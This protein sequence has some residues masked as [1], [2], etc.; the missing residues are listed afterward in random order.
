MRSIFAK[1]ITVHLLSA[2]VVASLLSILMDRE[3]SRRMNGSF[4]THGEVVAEALAKSV[5]PHL[6]RGDLNSV[7]ATIEQVLEI[8]DVAWAYVTAPDGQVVA[9]TFEPTIPAWVA[10]R[11]PGQSRAWSLVTIHGVKEPL[12][13]FDEPVSTGILGAVHVGFERDTLV[14]SIHNTKLV[15]LSSIVVVMLLATFAV[16]YLTSRIIKPMR[17][18][19]AAAM[20]FGKN[21]RFVFREIPVH[22]KDEV[23]VLTR[24]FNHMMG[25]IGDHHRQLEHRVEERT[26]MLERVNR[27]LR[28]LS[29]SNQALV[30]AVGEDELLQSVCRTIVE[31]GEY[32]LAWVGYREDD[33]EKT[34]RPVA[35]AGEAGGY[36]DFVKVTWGLTSRGFGPSGTAVRTGQPCIMN[37]MLSNPAFE[38]WREEAKRRQF[39]SMLAL[40]LVSE[41]H[42]FGVLNIYSELE[43]AF[44]DREVELLTE[45]AGNL[46]YGVIALRTREERRRAEEQLKTAKEAAEAANLAKSS[47]L[48]NMSHEIR[49]P[50][51][52]ILGMTELALETD[53]APEQ[54]EFLNIV[55]LSADSLLTII[56]DILDFSKIEAGRLDLES[57]PFNLMEVVNQKVRALALLAD[58]KNLE[59][60]CEFEPD[61]PET[62]VGDPFRLSQVLMNL[63]G[64]AIKF[65]RKGD[66]V[67]RVSL[68]AVRDGVAEIHFTVHDSGIGIATEKLRM[69]FEA[70]SQA[71]GSTT[72]K[73]GGTGLGLAIS[74]RLVEMMGGRIWVESELGRG[75]RFH[76]TGLFGQTAQKQADPG[77]YKGL[78]GTPVLVVDPNATT[79]GILQD[80]LNRWRMQPVLTDVPEVALSVLRAG[81]FPIVL[82][83]NGRGLDGFD[84]ASRIDETVGLSQ[85]SV[86]MLL[87]PRDQ[88]AGGNRCREMGWAFLSRPVLQAEL[89]Q[90]LQSALDAPA[91]S[92][93]ALSLCLLCDSSE[94]SQQI[95]AQKLPDALFGIATPQHRFGD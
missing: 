60:A 79:R 19:T 92:L 61:L 94:D 29:R 31:V 93:E 28:V 85:T 13:V 52:G 3:L 84:L 86:V 34:I 20:L 59:L 81:N 65:T 15:A 42:T 44:S 87:S 64:N 62:V 18:L 24:A 26:Q 49:T 45:L 95:S 78:A 91:R 9:H 70:F 75:S 39:R 71:D 58:E 80:I 69:I 35:H 23:G 33:F 88:A 55:K 25:Q 89:R 36:V 7:Q 77:M 46:A 90:V 54:R 76:F 27:A 40:P 1:L 43:N 56:D 47:F 68:E 5:E 16:G 53:L 22:S 83:A 4:L 10:A 14:S 12:A 51:N 21:N 30:R 41:E 73:Y 72:R 32:K 6:L 38:P 67:L 57:V 48:A 63:L 66:I 11:K 2:L 50:M 74:A 8:P 37:C 82:I 17:A